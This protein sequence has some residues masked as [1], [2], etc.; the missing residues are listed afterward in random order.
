MTFPYSLD[1]FETQQSDPQ[2]HGFIESYLLKRAASLRV[3]QP[4]TRPSLSSQQKYKRKP[5]PPVQRSASQPQIQRF[6]FVEARKYLS[7]PEYLMRTPQPVSPPRTPSPNPYMRSS[8]YLSPQDSYQGVE[9]GQSDSGYENEYRA[10]KLYQRVR[11]SSDVWS[12]RQ[13][14]RDITHAPPRSQS[15]MPHAY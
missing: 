10:K 11:K 4:V 8:E 2:S 13:F 12:D 15:A 3:A 7:P 9:C 14:I 6:E 1:L 5:L